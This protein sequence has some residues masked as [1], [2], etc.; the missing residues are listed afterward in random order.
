MEAFHAPVVV[1]EVGGELVEEFGMG[2]GAAH[3]AEVA[4]GGAEAAA[5]VVLPEA[6]GDDAGG[7]GVVGADEPGGEFGSRGC[8]A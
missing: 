7:E 8:S 3:D 2:D 1:A 4:G 5:E 6:V